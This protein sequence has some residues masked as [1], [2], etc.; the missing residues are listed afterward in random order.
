MSGKIFFDTNVVVYAATNNDAR[1]PL[2][3]AFLAAGG[4]ISAQVLNEFANTARR[5]LERSWPE[6]IDAVRTLRALCTECLPVT[7]QTHEAATRIARRLG[8][9]FYDSLII[10]SALE[11]KCTTLL[12]EDMQHGQVIDRRLIIA[13]PFRSSV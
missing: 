9:S 13:N 3:Q 8:Y 10:A 6:V 2:A 7:E 11:A 12:T 1:A 4:S 5:K